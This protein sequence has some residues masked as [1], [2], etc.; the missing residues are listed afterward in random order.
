MKGSN[1]KLQCDVPMKVSNKERQMQEI[2][3][4]RKQ[5]K[6]GVQAQACPFYRTIVCDT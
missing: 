1:S 2:H 5:K 3:N 4:I 6:D